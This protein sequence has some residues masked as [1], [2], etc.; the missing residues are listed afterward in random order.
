MFLLREIKSNITVNY[1]NINQ[2][3]HN[4]IERISI[5]ILKIDNSISFSLTFRYLYSKRFFFFFNKIVIYMDSMLK[6]IVGVKKII[7]Q[8]KWKKN[9][10][11]GKMIYIDTA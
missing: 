6:H 10:D 1:R 5:I 8:K 4:L 7:I 3:K 11:L 2:F 9:M